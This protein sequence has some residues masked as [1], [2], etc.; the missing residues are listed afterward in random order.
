MKKIIPV[1][2]S[3]SM[4]AATLCAGCNRPV[5]NG[6]GEMVNQTEYEA[7][8]TIGKSDAGK[9][10]LLDRSQTPA[11]M[12]SGLLRTDLL[13]NADFMESEET[14][15]YFAIAKETGM[16]TLE[17]SVMWSQVEPTYGNYEFGDLKN[18]LDFA[19]KYDLK[20]NLEWYGSFTDGEFHSAN[21]PSYVSRDTQTYPVLLDMLDYANY[22]RLR[23]MDWSNEAL[24]TRESRAIYEMMNYVYEWNRENDGYDPVIMVQI[25]Q[26]VDRFARWRIDGYKVKKADGSAFT[27]DEAWGMAR[28]YLDCVAKGVKYSKYKAITRVEFCEQNAVVNYVRNIEESEY[29]DVVCPTYLHEISSTKNAFKSFTDEYE[30][31]VVMNAENWASDI[32]HKQ[33]LATFGMGGAGYVSYQ[34]SN[35][36]Y[37]PESPNGALYKRYN[38]DG[39]TLAEKFV[40]KN[41]RAQDTKTIYTALQKA[42]VPVANA[43]RSCFATLGLNNLLN[44]KPEGERIQK[45]YFNNGLLLSYS[46]PLNSLG[47]AVYDSNYLYVYSTH[48]STLDIDNCSITVGQH[49]YFGKD[50][51]WVNEGN[52]TLA[53]NTRL[54]IEAGKI[55]RVRISSISELPSAAEL[56][57]GNYLTPLDSIRG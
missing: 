21:V 26:G 13:A 44:S 54:S 15:D 1:F 23:F 45:I 37:Y 4:I 8:Y 20:L 35:P 31:M 52:V 34:L 28:T 39:A 11:I 48:N 30:D 41:T 53:N 9:A 33:A 25:G 16:N 17:I 12:L 5:D 24:L 57:A 38:K 27:Q 29:I 7:P 36:V 3:L 40:Q 50:G 18:Y 42:F 56:K 55:Y 49:G 51:E 46:N 32:N 10:V 6:S 14:E 19:K 43:P 47:F 22:G 2:L